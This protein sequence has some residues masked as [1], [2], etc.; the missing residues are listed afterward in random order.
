[1]E[2]TDKHHILWPRSLWSTGYLK[3]LRQHWYLI[4]D[5]P[6]ETVH[7]TI[8]REMYG[9]PPANGEVTK[10]IVTHLKILERQGVL[11]KEDSIV[12]RL[13]IITALCDCIA[14][15]TASALK[16]QLEI[17]SQFF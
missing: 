15:K 3:E 4:V 6:T 12:R 11:S 13:T 7:K 5:I 9:V 8:H 2:K 1:M 17:A 14:P 16:Q 10:D